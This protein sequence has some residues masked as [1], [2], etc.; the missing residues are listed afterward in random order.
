MCSIGHSVNGASTNIFTLFETPYF[1]G[2]FGRPIVGCR[3]KFCAE[4]FEIS[5][6]RPTFSPSIEPRKASRTTCFAVMP[7]IMDAS[8]VEQYSSEICFIRSV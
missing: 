3:L 1:H 8:V 2:V 4:I 7:A 6:L 5:Q